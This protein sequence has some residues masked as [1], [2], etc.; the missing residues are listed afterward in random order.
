MT[1]PLC[2]IGYP[3]RNF[4]RRLIIANFVMLTKLK[5]GSVNGE[6]KSS[7]YLEPGKYMI[8]FFKDNATIKA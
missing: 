4:S 3:R 5:V 8:L 7:Y 6:R 1:I 2:Y